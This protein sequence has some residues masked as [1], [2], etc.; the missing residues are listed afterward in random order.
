MLVDEHGMV[1]IQGIPNSLEH[2][3]GLIR[4]EGTPMGNREWVMA[5]EKGKLD[6]R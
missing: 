5:A 6:S 1:R 3:E 2:L 4:E